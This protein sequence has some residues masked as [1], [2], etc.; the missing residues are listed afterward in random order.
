MS[1]RDARRHWMD[2]QRL[3]VETPFGEGPGATRAA[4]EH[5]GY[6]QIDTINVVERCHHQI[7][8]TRIPAYRRADLHHAQAVDKSIFEYWTHALA[9]VPTR[10]FCYFLGEMKRERHTPQRWGRDVDRADYR[11]MLRRIRDDGPITIRD[12]DDDELVDKTHPW[13]SRKPSKAALQRGFWEGLLAVSMRSG[14]VKTY[15][16]LDRHFGWTSPPRAA[17]ERQVLS[18]LLERAIRSQGIVSIASIVYGRRNIIGP[19]KDLVAARVKRRELVPVVIEGAEKVDHWIPAERL[20]S[21]NGADAAPDPD[22]VHILSP[23]DPLIIQRERTRRLFG[24]EHVFEAYVPRE[25]RRFGYFTHPVLAGDRIVAVLDL[26]ADRQERRLLVP[27]WHWIA[28]PD[29]GLRA[30]LESALH[31]FEAFQLA[32]LAGPRG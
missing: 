30:R 13:G 2:A 17:T 8:F 20:A 3:T 9:Y 7:L 4:I 32:E 24:Y 16:L 21:A 18:Y 11:R 14:M 29:K 6:V 15:D 10:D 23:F 5:L 28:N 1:Q 31:R 22:L 25:K 19:M 12:I 27:S 26:K